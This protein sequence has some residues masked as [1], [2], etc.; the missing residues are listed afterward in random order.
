MT[1]H[2]LFVADKTIGLADDGNCFQRQTSAHDNAETAHTV[3]TPCIQLHQCSKTKL[4]IAMP[5]GE[6]PHL[7]LNVA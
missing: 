7:L 5:F 2:P 6:Q 3:S 1:R 4:A